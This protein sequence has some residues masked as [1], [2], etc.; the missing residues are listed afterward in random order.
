LVFGSK[1]TN[2]FVRKTERDTERLMERSQGW[3]LDVQVRLP[4]PLKGFLSKPFDHYD[5]QPFCPYRET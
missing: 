5:P 3:S 2:Q 4:C 1:A